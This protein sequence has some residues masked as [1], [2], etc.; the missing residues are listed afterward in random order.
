MDELQN[1]PR[2]RGRPAK[3][4]ERGAQGEGERSAAHRAGTRDEVVE[5]AG[6]LR[7]AM[8][9]LEKF[10]DL[11]TNGYMFRGSHA[12]ALAA[13]RRR[14]PRMADDMEAL[15]ARSLAIEDGMVAAL[16][17]QPPE[18]GPRKGSI[19][20]GGAVFRVA[21]DGTVLRDDRA[22][23]LRINAEYNCWTVVDPRDIDFRPRRHYVARGGKAM[24]LYDAARTA[25]NENG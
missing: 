24:A 10:G 21:P 16:R 5:L 19:V 18:P 9:M 22:T 8:Q 23:G 6:R 3:D 25:M 12:A 13:V 2:R 17:G 15:S 14:V 20:V 7:F 4:A 11:A 1:P